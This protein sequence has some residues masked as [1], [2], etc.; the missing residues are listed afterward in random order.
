MQDT[1]P[2]QQGMKSAKFPQSHSS[3][4]SPQ[5]GQQSL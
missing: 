1:G 4:S 5:T 2:Y 3:S